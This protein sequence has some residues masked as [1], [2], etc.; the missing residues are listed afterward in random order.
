MIEFSVSNFRSFKDEQ[1]LSLVA[2]PDK[3]HEGNLIRG[4]KEKE[5]LFK[6]AAIYGANASGKSNLVAAIR[7]MESFIRRSATK[8]TQGDKILG[9]VPFRLDPESQGEPSSFEATVVADGTRY[10]YGFSVTSER[11]HSEWLTAYP[12][13]KP[14]RWFERVLDPET[15]QVKW[16]FNKP[17][18][19]NQAIL[20]EKTRPNG[21]VLSRGAELNIGPLS[22]LFLWFRERL[23]LFDLSAP[24]FF[25][26]QRTAEL[27][28]DND[29]F[30]NRV[31][32]LLRDAD[33]S[34]RG[35]SLAEKPLLLDQMPSVVREMLS[36]GMMKQLGDSTAIEIRSLHEIEGGEAEI[37]FDFEEAESNGTKRLFALAGPLLDALD[38][39][40]ILVVDELECSMHPLLTRKVIE[41]FQNPEVNKSGA[42]LI[43]FTHDSTLMDHTL[44]RRD[45]IW[46]TEKNANGATELF[47]LYDFKTDEGKP[48]VNEAFERRYLAGRYGAVPLFGPALEDAELE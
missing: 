42:Q 22:R 25:L 33:L 40:S 28:R 2:S 12:K 35:I 46:F 44:F 29:A 26:F 32:R 13:G 3:T 14:Q 39:G 27:M 18:R 15:Q 38:Q 21:L 19:G 34:I 23:W 7:F 8:M 10:V 5:N 4:D 47:S 24:P 6:V 20:K 36:D 30:R 31:T 45:Q 17:L 11:V 43:F 1:T 41:L 48:R 16:T 37:E 9:A